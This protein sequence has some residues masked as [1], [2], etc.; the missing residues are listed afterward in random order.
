M[1]TCELRSFKRTAAATILAVVSEVCLR[2][3]VVPKE[4]LAVLNTNQSVGAVFF[5][6][7]SYACQLKSFFGTADA[8]LKRE[9]GL[10]NLSHSSSKTS[11]S[12][13]NS[14]PDNLDKAVNAVFVR[15]S[16]LASGTVEEI[17]ILCSTL[18]DF[19]FGMDSAKGDTGLT[20]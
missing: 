15:G 5:N 9:S 8:F 1:H 20:I 6:S 3:Y 18:P 13:F 14:E 10:H 16:W 11:W 12:L 2:L 19:V 17:V 4:V 7:Y